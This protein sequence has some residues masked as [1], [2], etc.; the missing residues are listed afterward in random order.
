LKKVITA[1]LCL[2]V[3][4]LIFLNAWEGY[5]YND[6]ADRISGLEKQQKDLLESNRDAIAQIAYENS[7]VRIQERAVGTL[8]LAPLDQSA[9]TRIKVTGALDGASP[10]GT[11]YRASGGGAAA[12]ASIG[13]R[14]GTS[15]QAPAGGT[16][17]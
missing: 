12:R 17:Q 2:A 4:A 15:S 9:V 11:P 7:P 8:G 13:A 3:P 14:S 5:R 10:N 1:I 16:A 6:L